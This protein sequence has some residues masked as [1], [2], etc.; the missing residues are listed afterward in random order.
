MKTQEEKINYLKSLVERNTLRA[1]ELYHVEVEEDPN[2]EKFERLR[3][4]LGSRYYGCQTEH[5]TELVEEIMFLSL[6]EHVDLKKKK[7]PKSNF[8]KEHGPIKKG[9]SLTVIVFK[10]SKSSHFFFRDGDKMKR[11]GIHK[12]GKKIY[13]PTVLDKENFY[14][15]YR[16]PDKVEL[17]Q[18]LNEIPWDKIVELPFIED[19]FTMLEEFK[20]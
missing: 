8:S 15:N 19:L 14:Q 17:D 10:S 13:S 1:R 3:K 12:D 18:A 6:G 5:V 9:E 7:E 16:Y 20:I 2:D 4:I 11:V